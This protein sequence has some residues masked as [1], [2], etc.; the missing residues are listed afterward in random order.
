MNVEDVNVSNVSD[1]GGRNA[2]IIENNDVLACDCVKIG[3]NDVQKL[4]RSE[5]YALNVGPT[6]GKKKERFGNYQ[7]RK[8]RIE[9]SRVKAAIKILI[10]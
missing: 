7:E 2:E 1:Q 3:K 4:L 8:E 6:N 5:K 9:H 10:Y